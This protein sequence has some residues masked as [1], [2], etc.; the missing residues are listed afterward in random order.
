MQNETENII[1][2]LVVSLIHVLICSFNRSMT[3][4]IQYVHFWKALTVGEGWLEAERC[5]IPCLK[6]E[7]DVNSWLKF[8]CYD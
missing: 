1:L 5:M 2:P 3:L 8:R 7:E 6:G 4:N